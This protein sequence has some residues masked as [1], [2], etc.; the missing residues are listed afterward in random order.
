M[1]EDTPLLD[2]LAVMTAASVEA[3]NLEDRELM[4]ARIAALAAV[5]APPASYLVNAGTAVDVGITLEDVQGVL[6]AVAPIV[7]NGS[8]GERSR[9]PGA[10]PRLCDRG[11]GDRGRARRRRRLNPA[12][13]ATLTA[14][15]RISGAGCSSGPAFGALSH[16]P[17]AGAWF[18]RF[19]VVFAY[20]FPLLGVFWSL[21]MFAL[22]VVVDRH[23]DLVLRRQLP[24]P[25]PPRPRQG[26]LVPVHRVRSDHRGVQLPAHAPRHGRRG[27]GQRI[28]V[29]GSRESIAVADPV[30]AVRD[31]RSA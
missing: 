28:A 3:C 10:G 26:A 12:A 7:G 4:L 29:N 9:Q 20:D 21:L 5:G 17:S 19:P 8:G 30:C 31:V 18:R 1:A 15:V 16:H 27:C 6:I 24:S 11:V 23:R 14:I 22:F 13:A 2:T 25:R